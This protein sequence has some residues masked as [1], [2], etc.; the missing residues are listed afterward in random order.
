MSVPTAEARQH[1]VSAH[2]HPDESLIGY[3]FR[4]AYLRR[5]PY[6]RGLAVGCGF[7]E[8]TNRPEPDW[9]AALAADA[10][11]TLAELEAISNG[12]ALLPTSLYRG[13][14]LPSKVFGQ[15]GRSGRRVC[16]GCLAASAYHR[17]IWDLMFVAV[18]PVHLNVLVD[19]CRACGNPLRWSGNDVTR[20]G[21]GKGDLTRMAAA[22]VSAEDA[23]G[24]RTVYGLLGDGRFKADADRARGLEPFR[25]VGDGSIV[26]FI[27]RIGLEFLAGRGKVFSAE[28]PRELA[29]EAHVALTRGLEVAEGWPDAFF[30]AMD[31][32]RRRAPAYWAASLLQSSGAVERWLARLPDA[33]GL[34]IR[35]A[36]NEYRDRVIAGDA[37]PGLERVPGL[38]MHVRQRKLE[39]VK[40]SPERPRPKQSVRRKKASDGGD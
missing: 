24:T 38:S 6:A 8:L 10:R 19:T 37:P 28:H 2:P 15:R 33:S 32:M 14:E 16:P 36:C 20:C 31:M 13:V 23:R 21:C 9:L 18:C 11:V 17:A 5:A 12:S 22:P 4:L 26:D 39:M 34:V 30:A 35:A 40:P 27:Y 3:I 1:S 25:D 29:W 7:R